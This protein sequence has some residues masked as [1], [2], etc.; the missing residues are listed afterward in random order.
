MADKEVLE[1]NGTDAASEDRAKKEKILTLESIMREY[2]A[3][4]AAAEQKKEEHSESFEAF[5]REQENVGLSSDTVQE[6]DYDDSD[7]KIAVSDENQ[8][9]FE[10]EEPTIEF[11]GTSG[12][13]TSIEEASDEKLDI[14]NAISRNFRNSVSHGEDTPIKEKQENVQ[15]EQPS[16]CDGDCD[17]ECPPGEA[18]VI[19]NGVK[20]CKPIDNETLKKAFGDGEDLFVIP[21]KKKKKNHDIDEDVTKSE[22]IE[23]QNKK[24][25]ISRYDVNGEKIERD[26][27]FFS[28]VYE[29]T[30]GCAPETI[31]SKLRIKLLASCFAMVAV[32]FIL[33]ASFYTEIAPSVGLPH[34][35]ALEP[36]KTGVVF[37]L[38]DLQLLF[39]AVILKLNS[40]VR[41]AVGLFTKHK[42]SESIAF[43][44]VI[45]AVIHTITLAVGAPYSKDFVPVCSVACLSVLM[46]SV[47]DFL[48][49]RT[50][51]LAFRVVGSQA[52]K[53]AFKDISSDDEKTPDEIVK[54]VP[55]GSK[56]LD[57]RKVS[58]VDDFFKRNTKQAP[59]DKNTGVI[60]LS[61]LGASLVCAAIY[62]V[63]N[64]SPIYKAIC[65]FASLLLTTIQ[66][67]ILI[68]T[69][70]TESV[71]SERAARKKCAFIGHEVTDD[72][73]NV[74]VVSFKD[75][76]VFPPEKVVLTN[77]RMLGNDR[78]GYGVVIMARIFNKVETPIS[79][80]FSK[81]VT[82][83]NDTGENVTVVD[84]APDGLW[85]RVDGDNYYV[86]TA[87]YMAANNFESSALR[88]I[89]EI[90]GEMD[91]SVSVTGEK[92]EKP[93]SI[94]Y[95]AS[96]DCIIAEFGLKYTINEGFENILRSLYTQRICA[97]IKTL[98]PC[99]NNDFIRSILRRPEC[100]FSVV[101]GTDA[102]QAKKI[103]DF[104]SSSMVSSA[105]ENGLINSFLLIREM[106]KVLR[107]N[108]VLK[109]V[110][111]A[112]GFGVATLALLLGGAVLHPALILLL[113]L[114]FTAPIYLSAK[115][116]LK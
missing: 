17:I 93:N 49:A 87:S 30:K 40:I 97:R 27:K 47:S 70:L 90:I 28:P 6:E 26:S 101:K 65:A 94:L 48:R 33:I 99:I 14:M 41:G 86:G 115:F 32:F 18:C 42:T 100:L 83:A 107:L 19:E 61:A 38:F 96:S 84:I 58:F 108:A 9:D 4:K 75:T 98:D 116:A 21:K 88:S 85:V 102:E 82:N 50:E 36:G 110:A 2:D 92:V 34:F 68:S 3:K 37:M 5:C 55:E 112:A 10:H 24:E 103:E 25:K 69:S 7:M 46:L 80:L 16:V 72:F 54:Y 11:E 114:F 8:H 39:F 57:I 52:D 29:Y 53:Y 15:P 77:Y 60:I 59:A 56:V 89:D 91:G 31:F 66:S 45:A 35:K 12:E 64:A 105:N 23:P 111:V 109:T 43:V 104:I 51:Y 71:F 78:M 13:N 63:I 62:C 1:Q 67:C 44:S 113:Q 76:E 74:S 79:E 20:R 106:N 95:L 81:F 22:E 73:D